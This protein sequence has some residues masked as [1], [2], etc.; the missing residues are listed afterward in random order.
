MKAYI[1]ISF[2]NHKLMQKQLFAIAETLKKFEIESF[3]FVENYNFKSIQERKMMQQAMAEIERCDMLIAETSA[4][5][6]GIGVEVGYAKAKRKP[7]IYLRQKEAKHSTTVAGI[8]DFQIVYNDATDLK[9]Q[10]NNTLNI[11]L[12][13]SIANSS[14][15]F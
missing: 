1:A 5:G 7:V 4:K 2:S 6:I 8:S 10:L 3:V 11:I 12:E 15:S 13:T 14:K 9:K